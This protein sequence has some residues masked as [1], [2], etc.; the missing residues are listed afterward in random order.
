[1]TAIEDDLLHQ[2]VKDG[3][4]DLVRSAILQRADPNCAK[5][6]RCAIH[7]A[8]AQNGSLG[9]VELLLESEAYVDTEETSTSLLTVDQRQPIHLAAR[10]HDLELIMMLTRA[11]A[12]CGTTD[13]LGRNALHW[14]CEASLRCPL[15]RA[16]ALVTALVENGG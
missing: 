1:M 14:A 16:K 2:A 4:L 6:D 11:D 9:I 5:D 8:C 12:D 3:D 10:R 15:A 13:T 7:W